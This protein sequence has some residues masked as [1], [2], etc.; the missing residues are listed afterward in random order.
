MDTEGAVLLTS[1]FWIVF[2]FFLYVR[3]MQA[4][5][6][7]REARVRAFFDAG[8]T[9][10]REWFKLSRE[11]ISAALDDPEKANALRARLV[12]LRIRHA[13]AQ[14]ALQTALERARAYTGGERVGPG[15]S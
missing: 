3:K 5:D 1:A 15:R 8:E 9:D 10:L 6:V 2:G 7:K 11:D 13:Y 4:D 14:A 12:D